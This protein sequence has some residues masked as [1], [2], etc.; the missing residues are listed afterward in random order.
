MKE[1]QPN[2]FDFLPDDMIF[3]IMRYLDDKSFWKLSISCVRMFN[4]AQHSSI[5]QKILHS[6]PTMSALIKASGIEKQLNSGEIS[7]Y[8]FLISYLKKDFSSLFPL[9]GKVNLWVASYEL[10]TPKFF[11]C[12]AHCPRPLFLTKQFAEEGTP[13][14][15]KVKKWLEV[16]V[17]IEH[18]E[19]LATLIEQRKLFYL[20]VIPSS[21]VKLG[22]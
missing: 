19:D 13:N 20:S 10:P 5:C 15:R 14:R 12:P 2:P 16:Q 3:N 1:Q 9:V 7:A 8:R 22:I 11:Q 6:Y 17:H 18:A 21:H 4:L